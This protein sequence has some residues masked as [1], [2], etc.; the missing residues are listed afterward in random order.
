[1]SSFYSSLC[2]AQVSVNLLWNVQK[3][4][5]TQWFQVISNLEFGEQENLLEFSHSLFPLQRLLDVYHR[6]CYN[7]EAYSFVRLFCWL[8]ILFCHDRSLVCD[9]SWWHHFKLTET[10]CTV[11]SIL[12]NPPILS[13][14]LLF[15]I[16]LSQYP[17]GLFM[18]HFFLVTITTCFWHC[19]ASIS[20]TTLKAQCYFIHPC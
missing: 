12:A 3:K 15:F 13:K 5:P 17:L 10:L 2:V 14:R 19:T 1:M 8:K 20:P 4:G 11:H 7:Y 18:I 6:L 16:A 9:V